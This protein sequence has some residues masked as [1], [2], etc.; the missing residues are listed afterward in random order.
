MAQ[1]DFHA[2]VDAIEATRAQVQGGTGR[3]E[4]VRNFLNAIEDIVK[5]FCGECEGSL[6]QF[7]CE[8]DDHPAK[9]QQ[10]E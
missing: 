1:A 4:R 5:V 8:V 6:E 3:R 9:R 7:I 10:R 2:I